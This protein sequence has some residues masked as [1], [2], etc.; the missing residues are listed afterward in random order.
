MAPGDTEQAYILATV[1]IACD[2]GHNEQEVTSCL[3]VI[4]A[5][6]PATSKSIKWVLFKSLIALLTQIPRRMTPSMGRRCGWLVSVSG[7][8]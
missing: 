8:A 1:L 4:T 5:D 6:P 7:S 2:T 3:D